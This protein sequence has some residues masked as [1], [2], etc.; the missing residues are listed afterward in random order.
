MI[1]LSLSRPRPSR[2][3]GV[4]RGRPNQPLHPEGAGEA[5]RRRMP[6]QGRSSPARTASKGRRWRGQNGGH[7]GGMDR[8]TVTAPESGKRIEIRRRQRSRRYRWNRQ[9]RTAADQ[10]EARPSQLRRPSR[11]HHRCSGGA[12]GAGTPA[13][14]RGRLRSV[15]KRE[16]RLTALR[17]TIAAGKACREAGPA[18][19]RCSTTGLRVSAEHGGNLLLGSRLYLCG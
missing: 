18:A 19:P 17:E 16:I 9:G 8:E 7:Q 10:R 6:L 14:W 1:S 15:T 3:D 2:P 4:R 11:H 13:R 12:I 5:E